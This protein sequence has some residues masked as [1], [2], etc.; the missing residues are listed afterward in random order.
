MSWNG[1]Y[2]K[3]G[4][5]GAIDY[6]ELWKR[7]NS[8]STKVGDFTTPNFGTGAL[9]DG[10]D[11]RVTRSFSGVFE[12]F[13]AT[14]FT[15]A[16]IPT[17][18]A[19]VL[20]DNSH[21]ATSH[22][23]VYVNFGTGTNTRRVY[24]DNLVIEENT[25]T[26]CSQ[27]FISEYIQIT[28]SVTKCFLELYNPSPNP[29][30]LSNYKLWKITDGG[31]WPES[32]YTF[33]ITS[34]IVNPYETY[35]IGFSGP[36]FPNSDTYSSFLNMSGNDAI[37]LAY[38]GGN[39]TVFNLIDAIGTDGTAPST[40]WDV[41]GTNNATRNKQLTRKPSVQVP[42]TDWASSAG[43]NTTNSEWTVQTY[44]LSSVLPG[45][46][47]ICKCS[48][49]VK[50]WT[51]SGWSPTGIPTIDNAIVIDANYNTNIN[52]SID[53]CNCVVNTSKTVMIPSGTYLNIKNDI[54]N[55]GAVL[56]QHEG[57]IV[58]LNDYAKSIGINL[59]N[60]K[61]NNALCRI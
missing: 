14:G 58:Q 34:G 41:A 43:T 1:Y 50:T 45:H 55:N 22:F 40:A 17:T 4:A 5:S 13:Y 35:A 15:Y 53:A 39:G 11:I 42:N 29:I 33:Q 32:V 60:T 23:G 44:T 7:T 38:N 57:S 21:T 37:G 36:S 30:D 49:N 2:L 56:A 10:L 52:G 31:T 8:T 51:T 47:T 19:G 18:S 16:T 48:G 12:L 54:V 6:I 20:I 26:N 9:K 46:T 27:L 25:T 61:N 24:L 3:L 59:P 28:F